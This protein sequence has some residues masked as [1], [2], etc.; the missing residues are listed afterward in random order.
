M[1]VYISLTTVPD[2]LANWLQAK[3]NLISLLTQKTQ[4]KYSVIYN[5][6]KIYKINNSEYTITDELLKLREEYPHL[7]LHQLDK[8]YGA[9]TKII[10]GLLYTSQPDDLLIV[11]DDDHV[12]H[13]DMV[14]VHLENRRKYSNYEKFAIAFRGDTPID[15]RGWTENNQSKYVLHISPGVTFP[16]LCDTRVLIPAHWHSVSYTRNIFDDTFLS[17]DF[18]KNA[19]GDDTLAGLYLKQKRIPIF[20]VYHN[21]FGDLRPV[22]KLSRTSSSFPIK[23]QLPF[24]ESGFYHYRTGDVGAA[25]YID[26]NAY[27]YLFNC[28]EVYDE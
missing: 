14:E 16:V 5:L 25:G 11:C 18:L 27:A 8:D 23:E 7:I 20:C 6:P 13:E 21:N 24:N 19:T 22:N 17:E 2:R 9:V 10:G 1:N 28:D 3:R 26:K 4:I 12:Y 15:K